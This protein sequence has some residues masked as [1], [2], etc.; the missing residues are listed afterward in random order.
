MVNDKVNG[1]LEIAS[2]VDLKKYEVDFLRK[3]CESISSTVVTMNINFKTSQL[4]ASTQS[5]A[6]EMRAQEE[7]MRQNMEEM[8]A[9]QEEFTR[10]E[11]Q[12]LE[13]IARLKK[14]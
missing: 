11:I 4:L 13:E 1:V 12:Y 14:S 7:E 9:T 10:K 2:F 6:E 5:Q 3:A 8:K